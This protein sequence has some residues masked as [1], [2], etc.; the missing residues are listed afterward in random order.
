MAQSESLVLAMKRKGGSGGGGTTWR[1]RPSQSFATAVAGICNTAEGCLWEGWYR[2]FVDSCCQPHVQPRQLLLTLLFLF[3]VCRW[4]SK[5]R[6]VVGERVR[7]PPAGKTTPRGPPRPGKLGTIIG[8]HVSELAIVEDGQCGAPD[9]DDD[10]LVVLVRV[11][12]SLKGKQLVGQQRRARRRSR[13]RRRSKRGRGG[14]DDSD[15]RSIDDDGDD[16]G[17]KH[18]DDNATDGGG[19]DDDYDSND[20]H[21]DDYDDDGDDN[22]DDDDDCTGSG[23]CNIKKL[24]F[25]RAVKLLVSREGGT[26]DMAA[27]TAADKG[28]SSRGGERGAHHVKPFGCVYGGCRC[29]FG[30]RSEWY[31]HIKSCSKLTMQDMTN[32]VERVPISVYVAGSKPEGEIFRAF[33]RYSLNYEVQSKFVKIATAHAGGTAHKSSSSSG[34][35]S[36]GGGG[37]GGRGG[38]SSL[39][40]SSSSSSSSTCV[41][42]G[43]TLKRRNYDER[44]HRTFSGDI[45][46]ECDHGVGGTHP[47]PA[48]LR[49]CCWNAV[50]QQG[51]KVPLQLFYHSDKGWGVRTLVPI[52]ANQFVC[53][54]VGELVHDQEVEE[55]YVETILAVSSMYNFLIELRALWTRQQT[56]SCA[57]YVVCC[58][59]R[60][61]GLANS[62]YLLNLDREDAQGDSAVVDASTVGNVAR[63]LNHSCA[64]NLQ[65]QHVQT[66]GVTLRVVNPSDNSVDKQLFTRLAFFAGRNIYR[67]EELTWDYGMRKGKDTP[68]QQ[69]YCGS[70]SCRGLMAN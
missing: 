44:A 38:G 30:T 41:E 48:C 32:G 9:V 59:Y 19:R 37:G 69:C 66:A 18:D 65:K 33:R 24:K 25:L 20:D 57:T 34:S 12:K 8:V 6:D 11:D 39:L 43:L 28:G 5:E 70:D 50:V 60:R 29:L 58:R 4:L 51:I 7:L 27:A 13:T 14:S 49:S 62:D 47:P 61:K 3:L 16:D 55:R 53:E 36:S 21:D 2:V 31:R 52:L 23:N 45:I 42:A 40:S 22:D 54:Y 10:D 15:R 63:F 68:R 46:V 67:M 1:S 56:R 26:P 17:D 64:P 35:S